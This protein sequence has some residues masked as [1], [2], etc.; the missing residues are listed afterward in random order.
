MVSARLHVDL[1][2]KMPRGALA[3]PPAG[4]PRGTMHPMERQGVVLEPTLAGRQPVMS[5]W[6]LR[7]RREHLRREHRRPLWAV[8]TQQFADRERAADREQASGDRPD[9]QERRG[10]TI[11]R[12]TSKS[13]RLMTLTSRFFAI[14]LPF[15]LHSTTKYGLE[16]VAISY[17][18]ATS[19][20]LVVV[21]LAIRS[22]LT[23]AYLIP[24]EESR[25]PPS[26]TLMRTR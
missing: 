15:K 6:P 20:R 16:A 14:G 7:T 26:T 25:K 19:R 17:R 11:S 9:L 12:T 3:A 24:A 23:V 13:I 18:K 4:D 8:V 21:D 1:R 22:S 10:R 2:R 5:L